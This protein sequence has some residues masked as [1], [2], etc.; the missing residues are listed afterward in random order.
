[1][2]ALYLQNAVCLLPARADLVENMHYV[3]GAIEEI[4]GTCHLFAAT[5]LLPG[6]F[7][8]LE[9]DFRAQADSRLEELAARLDRV[10]ASLDSAASPS[11]LE[12]AEEDLKRERIAY[13][14]ARRLA[15]FGS[16]R[17]SE[18]DSRLED[19]KRALDDLYRSGK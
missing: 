5:A 11:A 18:V 3:A 10:K 12:Q 7:E 4:G 8:S 15:F 19:L 16:S 6:D 9:A 1:M 13:L 2:G 17:E 14:R